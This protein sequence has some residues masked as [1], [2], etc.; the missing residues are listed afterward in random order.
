MSVARP[1]MTVFVIECTLDVLLTR[2]PTCYFFGL[3]CR[4]IDM[5]DLLSSVKDLHYLLEENSSATSARPLTSM[6]YETTVR[7]RKLDTGDLK[8]VLDFAAI[9]PVNPRWVKAT[10]QG[11]E[12]I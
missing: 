10:A 2:D 7:Q 6:Q 3:T 4:G 1:P 11:R 5:C 12:D 9:R 8:A